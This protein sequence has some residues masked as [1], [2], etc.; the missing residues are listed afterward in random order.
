MIPQSAVWR[1]FLIGSSWDSQT[2]MV[3]PASRSSNFSPKQAITDSLVSTAN[4]VLAATR[5]EVSP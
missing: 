4:L 3:F 5:S 1:A 2:E